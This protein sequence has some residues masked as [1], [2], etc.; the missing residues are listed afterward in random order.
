MRNAASHV[1]RRH[2]LALLGTSG[3]AGGSV[4][5]ACAAP[6]SPTPAPSAGPVDLILGHFV[7]TR[8]EYHARLLE[9]WTREVAERSAGRVRITI[10][11]GGALGPAPAQ[12]K[13]VTA[14]AMDIGLGVH[15]Y[16]PGRFP[17]TESLELPFLWDSG[18]GATQAL[19]ALYRSVPTVRNE[20]ADAKVLALWA[21]GPAYL[22]TARTPVKTLEDLRGLKLRSPGAMHNKTIEALG[23]VPLST[24]VTEVY[25]ALDR[26]VV[27]GTVSAPSTFAS[28][29]LAEVVTQATVARFTVATFFLVM[30]AQKWAG[31]RADDQRL[32]D[33]LADEPLGLQAA[34]VS[35]ETDTAGI[36]LARE[37]G[38]ELHQ[39]PADELRRWESAAAGVSEQWI[40]EAQRK[41]LPG[42]QVYDLLR[43]RPQG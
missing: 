40:A 4:L 16:T 30:N 25:D 10:H 29:N 21:N 35:D 5:A 26:G 18:V 7:P 28:F 38:V 31:L 33:E 14:G 12:Y 13:S 34:R 43:Q 8:H 36:G 20:Y 24:P 19:Q 2:V 3:V 15:S 37:R 1:S 11:P 22:M 23:A 17:L 9:P 6:G 41:G 42:R 27:N 39:L 32:L